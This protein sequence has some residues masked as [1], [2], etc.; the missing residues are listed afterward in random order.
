MDINSILPLLLG[1]KDGIDKSKIFAMLS[2]EKEA[3]SNDTQ[4]MLSLLG[5]MK[6]PHGRTSVGLS[7]ITSF[8]P[9]E[10]I[11]ALVKLLA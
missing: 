1:S 3:P 5:N 7:V 11:G 4:K 2:G 8:A 10:I 6:K 9:S